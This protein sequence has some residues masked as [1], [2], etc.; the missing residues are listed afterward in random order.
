MGLPR[1]IRPEYS[2]TI[3]STGKKIKYNP[4][5]VREEKVLVLASESNDP[6]EITNAIVNVLQNCITSPSDIKVEELAIFDIEFL[7]LKARSKSVGEYINIRVTDPNDETFTTDHSI[8]I[9]R[10][11][12]DRTPDHSSLIFLSDDIQVKMKYPGIE[13]FAEGIDLSSITNSLDTISRCIESVITGDEVFHCV[14]T[15]KKELTEWL[16][17]L[18]SEQFRRITNFFVTMPKL[19]HTFTVTNDNTGNDFKITLEGLSDFF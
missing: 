19:R 14:D 16:E 7:F 13:F 3:P 10:I 18:T 4:F 17:G 8:N 2:T 6:E 1:T 11:G 5:S 12:I 9:D 15:T